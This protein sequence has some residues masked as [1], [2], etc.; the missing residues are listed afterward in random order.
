MVRRG[1]GIYEDDPF[2]ESLV[3]RRLILLNFHASLDVEELIANDE[4]RL[5]MEQAYAMLMAFSNKSVNVSKL[6]FFRLFGRIKINAFHLT[7]DFGDAIGVALFERSAKLD[8]SCIPNADF[9]F[10]GKRIN[11][12]AS[13][14]ILDASQIRI[15]YVDVLMSTKKRQEE[16]FNGY[17]FVCN[18][19]RCSDFEQD[20]DARI[21]PCCGERMRRLK[22]DALDDGEV[23]S[24]PPEANSLL[25]SLARYSTLAPDEVYICEKC[26]RSYDTAVFD[27]LEC[28]CYEI[29]T[30]EDA[31]ELYKA[32]A[33]AAN[34]GNNGYLHLVYN[35]QDSL[36]L[37]RLCRTMV[38]TYKVD[39][40]SLD[41]E[42][43]DLMLEAG[44][45]LARCFD[46]VGS[47]Y[48][49]FCG[50]LFVCSLVCALL[51]LLGS[52]VSSME[53][54]LSV[55]GSEGDIDGVTLERL[56]R[57]SEA[58]VHTTMTFVPCIKRFALHLPCVSEQL[59]RL[60]RFANNL[61][62]KI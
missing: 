54:R 50:H 43:L 37:L 6:H 34:T 49:D 20:F 51:G 18:C 41:G 13:D 30:F 56:G 48:H 2:F 52:V 1:A 53:T 5:M 24:W 62:V 45:R 25:P 44:L 27:A 32:C 40:D 4:T 11:V 60:R 9:S 12:I 57:F 58:F 10:V 21:P 3:S 59:H 39:E 33:A 26:H 19:R 46:C 31:I 23:V 7:N 14:E 38:V 29:N 61:N 55:S 35:H 22:V 36:S 47:K 16:L 17:F 15:S 42:E 8:H 28:R